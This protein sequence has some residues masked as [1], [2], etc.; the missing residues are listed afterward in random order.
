M[1]CI[2]EVFLFVSKSRLTL[3]IF[4]LV[5]TFSSTISVDAA[6]NIKRLGT[7]VT[8]VVDTHSTYLPVLDGKSIGVSQPKTP[9]KS[10]FILLP[11]TVKYEAKENSVV[12]SITVL[13]S[14]TTAVVQIPLDLF[15][16]EYVAPHISS[17]GRVFDSGRI[18]NKENKPIGLYSVSTKNAPANLKYVVRIKNNYMLEL[19]ITTNKLLNPATINIEVATPTMSTYFSS[20]K[21]ITRGNIESLSLI[22]NS[23]ILNSATSDISILKKLDAWDKLYEI[24]NSDTKWQNSTGLQNQFDCHYDFAKNK[25]EWNIEPTRKKVSYLD[26]IKAS[27]NP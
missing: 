20:S 18:Y 2:L 27:C 26:T 21:W 4:M 8:N 25:S 6:R 13:P 23:Y 10:R 14:T 22:P 9:Q 19:S 24:H 7:S 1:N 12:Q 15:Y 17:N 11:K 3:I 16:G 5:F